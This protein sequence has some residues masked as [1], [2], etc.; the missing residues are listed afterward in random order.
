MKAA[1]YTKY[2]SPE[3]LQI[4]EVT[5]P[6]WNILIK[7]TMNNSHTLKIIIKQTKNYLNL[8]CFYWHI[9][10]LVN[11]LIKEKNEKLRKLTKTNLSSPKLHL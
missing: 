1:V 9:F 5:K 2:G 4:K 8:M 3:V 6:E 11:K 7:R 10:V